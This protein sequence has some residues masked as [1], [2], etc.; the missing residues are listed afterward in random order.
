LSQARPNT[1]AAEVPLDWSAHFH[2]GFPGDLNVQ[3]VP[4]RKPA[5]QLQG[6]AALAPDFIFKKSRDKHNRACYGGGEE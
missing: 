3:E 5:L 6:A 2:I 1:A 4:G